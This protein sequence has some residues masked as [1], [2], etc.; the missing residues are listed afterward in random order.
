MN[1]ELKELE[2]GMIAAL[3]ERIVKYD[4]A[5]RCRTNSQ[6]QNIRCQEAISAMEDLKGEVS[7]ICDEIRERGED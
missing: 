5:L 4:R 6:D 1:E 7:A 3:E 2:K